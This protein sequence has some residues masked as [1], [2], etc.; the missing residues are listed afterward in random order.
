MYRILA[1]DDEGIVI[2]ALKHII[3]KE[4]GEQV[5]LMFAKSGREAIAMAE[6][7]KPQI[8]IMDINMPGINGIDAIKEI[9][10]ID[11]RIKVIVLSAFDMFDYAQK[12][13]NLGVIKY[14]NKPINRKEIIEVIKELM[15]L[16]DKEKMKR[17]EQMEVREKLDTV[18][19]IIEN[20]LIYNLI[21]EEYFKED[22]EHY[23]ELLGITSNYACVKIGRA[24]V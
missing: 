7:M 3:V 15:K 9:K 1:A 23:K 24:H 21:F 14:L 12:A 17:K 18:V 13:M 2:E 10:S 8:V 19:P 11:E 16:V 4:F 20:G 5:E 22:I 6:E